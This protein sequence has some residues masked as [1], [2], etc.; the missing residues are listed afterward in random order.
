[1][2]VLAADIWKQLHALG[3]RDTTVTL[4]WVPGHAGLDGNEDVDQLAGEAAGRAD[5][6]SA[7][8]VR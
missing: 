2:T 5:R 4:Q 3:E 6:L 1:M 8:E 7:L